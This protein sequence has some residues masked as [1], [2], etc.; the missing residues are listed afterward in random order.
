MSAHAA[1][2]VC[3]PDCLVSL[4]PSP[5]LGA[6]LE[7]VGAPIQA[8]LRSRPDTIRC[9]VSMLTQHPDD[10]GADGDTAM[11]EG[12]GEEGGSGG[13]LSAALGL[14][15]ALL[16]VP[17]GGGGGGGGGR[18]GF[19]SEAEGDEA[20]LKLLEALEAG[21]VGCMCVRWWGVGR[22]VRGACLLAAWACGGM[23]ACNLE[24]SFPWF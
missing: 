21:E 10:D 8:Y 11:M 14:G 17:E 18:G 22:L 1:L 24:E 20:A 9:V 16:R 23:L 6:V 4:S 3:T 15:A 19:C 7:V 2:T 12:G 5:F 13:G